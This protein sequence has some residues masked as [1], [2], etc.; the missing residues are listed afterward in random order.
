MKPKSVSTQTL[1]RLPLYR[2]YLKTLPEDGN[3]SATTIADALKLN[4]V[5]VRKDLSAIS[6]G[7]RPKVGYNTRG[8]IADIEAFLRYNDT[9]NAVIIGVGNLGHALLS[10][11]GFTEYGLNIVAGF[12]VRETMYGNTVNGK[13]IRPAAELESFCQRENIHI[14]IIT[15]PADQAQGVCDILIRCGILAIWNFA[16]THLNVP[17]GVLVQNENMA[18][19]LAILSQHLA[20]KMH[21]KEPD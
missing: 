10:F 4:P 13:P 15:V 9:D 1:K 2:T 19:S 17:A 20:E 14:G 5:Q 8:L 21:E 18:A 16:P 7:G 6:D 11:K 12:D 3:V